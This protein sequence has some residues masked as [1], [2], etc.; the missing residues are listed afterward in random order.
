[1][2]RLAFL[3][4]AFCLSVSAVDVF[5]EAGKDWAKPVLVKSLGV[6]CP[7]GLRQWFGSFAGG[8]AI[9]NS[10]TYAGLLGKATARL[11]LVNE[12]LGD[13]VEDWI[14]KNLKSP[15]WIESGSVVVLA[16]DKPVDK[17]SPNCQL[18]G[19]AF[20]RYEASSGAYQIGIS[21]KLFNRLSAA[22]QVRTV[23]DLALQADGARWNLSRPPPYL[24]SSPFYLSMIGLEAANGAYLPEVDWIS[25]LLNKKMDMTDERYRP[26]LGLMLEGLRRL[27][28]VSPIER[29]S[30]IEYALTESAGAGP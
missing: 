30:L 24:K 20:A 1:M 7:A 28:F 10:L 23:L 22:D 29:S 15:H 4:V 6:D 11:K 27:A 21:R 14:A 8:L 26:A 18:V 16:H 2:S 9:P 17:I 3:C 25:A 13:N 19:I 5:G 12:Y